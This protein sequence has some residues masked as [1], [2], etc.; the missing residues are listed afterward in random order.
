MRPLY[1]MAFGQLLHVSIDSHLLHTAFLKGRGRNVLAL[2]FYAQNCHKPIISG[3]DGL[4]K[5][6]DFQM[7]FPF[8]PRISG[9]L[10]I[11]E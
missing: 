1:L 10:Q 9:H 2:G 7:T 5:I 3:E 8:P 11:C 4:R 6:S